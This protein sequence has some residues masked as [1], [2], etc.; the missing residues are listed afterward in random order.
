MSRPRR[1][2]SGAVFLDADNESVA[3]RR[4]IAR[5][6]LQARLSLR[7]LPI[8]AAA[9]AGVLALT[10]LAGALG[11]PAVAVPAPL[12]QPSVE[13]LEEARAFAAKA[14]VIED[15]AEVDARLFRRLAAEERQAAAD[16]LAAEQAA[17]DK[18]AA[19]KA[20]AEKA[21]AEKAAAEK[22]AA[23]KAAAEKAAAEKKAAEK[24]AVEKKAA[25]EKTSTPSSSSSS[26][27]STKSSGS[28]APASTYGLRGS[29]VEV[30]NAVMSRFSGINSV[31]GYRASSLSNHQLGLAIDFMLTPGAESDLGWAIAKYV[32]AN[33]SAFNVDHVIFEQKIWSTASPSW[34]MMEDRGSTTAN[35]YDHVHVSVKG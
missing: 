12:G 10:P 21:A 20:A 25:A 34:R 13:A 24:A 6:T 15:S 32:V 23:E 14:S 8:A 26:Y 9:T 5:P 1:A 7:A 16:K 18:K 19:E 31:G 22:A 30:Y 2:V 11:T 17:A 35:H 33:A 27:V 28:F 3:P 4:G 29:A